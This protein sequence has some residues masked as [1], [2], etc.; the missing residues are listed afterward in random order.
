MPIPLEPLVLLNN[1]SKGIGIGTFLE[2]KNIFSKIFP[3]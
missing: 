3:I 1:S 2:I